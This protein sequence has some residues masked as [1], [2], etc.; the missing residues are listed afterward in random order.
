MK[1]RICCFLAGMFLAAIFLVGNAIGCGEAKVT[2]VNPSRHTSPDTPGA[3]GASFGYPGR[4]N[5]L[6]H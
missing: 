1:S 4:Q 2:V 6:C 3:D 5:D